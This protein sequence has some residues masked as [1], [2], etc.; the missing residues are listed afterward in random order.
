MVSGFSAV[1]RKWWSVQRWE[2][3]HG[4]GSCVALAGVANE[5]Q[6]P[7]DDTGLG[8]PHACRVKNDGVTFRILFLQTLEAC[9]SHDVL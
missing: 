6:E 4:W 8:V 5:R 9:N 1:V 2:V 3:A 7:V